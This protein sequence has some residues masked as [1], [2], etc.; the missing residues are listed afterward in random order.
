MR[1][2]SNGCVVPQHR[3][4]KKGTLASILEQAGVTVEEFRKAL[5]L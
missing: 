3:E 5:G 4:I 2:S 1:R